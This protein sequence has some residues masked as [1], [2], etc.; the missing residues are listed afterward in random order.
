MPEA[1]KQGSLDSLCGIYSVVNA[2][3]WVLDGNPPRMS[4]QELFFFVI[5][6]VEREYGA[7]KA[8]VSGID[9]D[10]LWRVI[11]AVL[12][13]LRAEYEVAITAERPFEARRRLTVA[14]IQQ[15]L[16]TDLEA[17]GAAY[18]VVFWGRLD[19][20]SVVRRVTKSSFL[21][22]DSWT[23]TRIPI[24]SCSVWRGE[25]SADDRLHILEVGGII[26]L[27]R[28]P[29]ADDIVETASA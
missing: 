3:R 14:A 25:E 23:Y 17:S 28:E 16:V 29:L 1:M 27:A 6:Q 11:V 9:P 12:D 24:E 26:R 15:T 5:G 7:A 8:I 13:H 18:I 20:W 10:D 22:F 19:H 2:I 21:L 4:A